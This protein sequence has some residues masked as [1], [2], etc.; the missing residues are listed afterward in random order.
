M[1]LRKGKRSVYPPHFFARSFRAIV[2]GALV[3][4]SLFALNQIKLGDYFPIKTVRVYGV[5]HVDQKE[6]Q[7]ILMPLVSN[8]F[9]TINVESIRDRLVLMPW[10]SDIFV[11]RGWPDLVE[12][13]VVEKNPI[14]RWNQQR[15]LSD[16]GDL[17]APKQESYPAHLPTFIG[18]EGAQMTMLNYYHQ[19]N[20]LF[21][22]LHVKISYLEM[23]PYA[24]WKVMLDNGVTL[25]I[26]HKDILTRL[27]HFVKVYPKIIGEHAGD[28]EYVDLRYPNGLAV[29]WKSTNF[30]A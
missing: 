30:T 15:L 7:T 17:F 1:Q 21:M 20:R 5:Q 13:T 16:A 25:Q 4:S 26:G 12:I 22:P 19:I 27:N 9:F 3:L 18:P 6:I 10:V 14:A 24:T 28:V 29:R 8:G 23:T 11:R 2:L